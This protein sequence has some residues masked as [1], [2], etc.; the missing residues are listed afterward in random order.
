MCVCVCVCVCMCVPNDLTATWAS[1]KIAS[2]I[3]SPV[4]MPR[5]AS[6]AR[7]IP[8]SGNI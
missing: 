1:D 3:C 4:V 8:Q 7:T 5:L 2:H 6:G